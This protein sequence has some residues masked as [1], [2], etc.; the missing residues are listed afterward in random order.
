M[1]CAIKLKK[2]YHR[3]LLLK[4]TLDS[5]TG[6]HTKG[7]T[8]GAHSV[9]GAGAVVTKDVPPYTVVVVILPVS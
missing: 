4:T 2:D 1:T 6:H 3:Q 7:I 5:Y 9:V 8:I